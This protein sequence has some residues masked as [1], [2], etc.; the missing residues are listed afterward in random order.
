MRRGGLQVLAGGEDVHRIPDQVFHE[1]VQLFGSL[2][3]SEHHSGLG[4][5]PG[6][7]FLG[8]PQQIERALVPRSGPDRLVEPRHRFHVVVEDLG[9][10]LHHDGERRPVSLEVRDQHLDGGVRTAPP[11]GADGLR[12]DAG[13]PVRQVVAVHRSDHRVPEIH[14]LDGIGDPFRFFEIE[15]HRTPRGHRAE[16]AGPGAD[17]TQDHEGG[18]ALAPALRNVG[19]ASF[20]AH[21]V[22]VLLAEE[23]PE[24]PPG[25]AGRDPHPEPVRPRTAGGPGCDVGRGARSRA[26]HGKGD[27]AQGLMSPSGQ[28]S[29]RDFTAAMN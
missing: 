26:D 13:A 28:F 17:V 19:A 10:L 16:P 15:T 12:E 5:R 3:E 8:A 25:G 27:R 24:P 11:D 23:A 29:S 18:R 7:Q 6:P 20:L 4:Q 14:E 9:I 2:P 22:E 1:R 21:R